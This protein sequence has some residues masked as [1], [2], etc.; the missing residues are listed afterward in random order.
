MLSII[1]QATQMTHVTRVYGHNFV[2]DDCRL[3]QLRLLILR[4]KIF[5]NKVA[6][7]CNIDGNYFFLISR[8]I[9]LEIE[10]CSV[11]ANPVNVSRFLKAGRE[12]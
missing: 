6:F 7:V 8:G 4:N 9:S 2:L 11:V 12:A 3:I 1:Q 5:E 10:Q